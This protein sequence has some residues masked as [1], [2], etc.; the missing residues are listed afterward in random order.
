MPLLLFVYAS[1]TAWGLLSVALTLWLWELT[2]SLLAALLIV[3]AV[4]AALAIT[5]YF[6][7]LHRVIRSINR[8][9]DTV[10]EVSAMFDRVYR[11]IIA[12]VRQLGL[13]K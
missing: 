2:G 9:L 7:S 6:A 11:H 13:T 3:I 12:F 4:M 8:R 5:I 10:Y 1:L